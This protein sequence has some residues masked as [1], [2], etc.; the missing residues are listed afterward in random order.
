MFKTLFEISSWIMIGLLGIMAM[1]IISSNSS[2]FA[3]YQSYLVQSGSME[4]AIMTGD[5]VIIHKQNEYIKND[6]VT[7]KD[8]EGRTV[9][10]RIIKIDQTDGNQILS[11][12]GDANRSED[13]D[14]ISQ[15]QIVGKV[16]FVIPKIGYLVAFSKSLPGLII[17]V[18]IPAGLFIADE[19]FKQ[20][21][22]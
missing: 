6:V 10:H 4:P 18:L 22:A 8:K 16:A 14:T 5:I 9:T 17:M 3:G 13:S 11:T 20:K 21:N 19:L 12:K 7:F 2:I 15:E 1:Y